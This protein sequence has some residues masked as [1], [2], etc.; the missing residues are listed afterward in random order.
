MLFLLHK[1]V[2]ITG[3]TLWLLVSAVI[4]IKVDEHL[5]RLGW[6]F[7]AIDC[8]GRLAAAAYGA[9]PPWIVDIGGAEAW[10]L[11]QSLLYTCPQSSRYWPDC[12]PV[13]LAVE[14]GPKMA[15][16]PRFDFLLNLDHL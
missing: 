2:E 8:H 6:S 4:A 5:M 14:K 7:C 13:K 9:P 16:D 11:Y 12:Y 10:G 3:R 1:E 15:M